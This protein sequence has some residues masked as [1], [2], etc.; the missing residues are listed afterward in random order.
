M[1]VPLALV[2]LPAVVMA[3]SASDESANHEHTLTRTVTTTEG[4]QPPVPSTPPPPIVGQPVEVT[5]GPPASLTGLLEIHTPQ[6]PSVDQPGL[7]T[8][9]LEGD[10]DGDGQPGLTTAPGGSFALGPVRANT[11]TDGGLQTLADDPSLGTGTLNSVAWLL[12]QSRALVAK[13][14]DASAEAAAIQVASWSLTGEVRADQPTA[15]PE[16][17]ARVKV[18][19][20]QAEGQFLPTT[21]V[22]V[23]AGHACID[24]VT[25]VTVVGPPGATVAAGISGPGT[26]LQ[27]TTVVDGSGRANLA[28]RSNRPGTISIAVRTPGR[29]LARLTT[30]L[31][32]GAASGAD[33][34]LSLFTLRPA[35]LAGASVIG[36]RD[37][38]SEMPTDDAVPPTAGSRPDVLVPASYNGSGLLISAASTAAMDNG[39]RRV[40]VELANV[41]A[42]PIG[43]VLV[44]AGIPAGTEVLSG[45]RD[46]SPGTVG[47][48]L[49][50]IDPGQSETVEA[51]VRK[52]PGAA[53]T[54]LP[55][56]DGRSNLNP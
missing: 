48:R 26:L 41:S 43:D 15:S 30:S 36:S 27:P 56:E 19:T 4:D 31:P 12:S 37:C 23:S 8:I 33:R 16:I 13:A 44:S 5:V 52:S 38:T 53:V 1:L 34:G 49:T 9:T 55:D 2:A 54:A 45:G 11:R 17:N 24:Q 28:F 14:S 7:R 6:G 21:L 42:K 18:L 32:S 10:S 47:W 40:R 3:T 35:E 50:R 29:Q 22:A 39:R 51:I 20:A 25:P 46:L